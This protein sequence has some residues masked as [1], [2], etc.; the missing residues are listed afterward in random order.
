MSSH[1]IKIFN[2]SNN[3]D[4]PAQYLSDNFIIIIIIYLFVYFSAA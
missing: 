3:L 2:H 4:L 1:F